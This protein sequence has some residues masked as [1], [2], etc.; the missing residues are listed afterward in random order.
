MQSQNQT[1]MTRIE[2]L[3]EELVAHYGDG[4]AKELRVAAKMLMVSLDQFRRHGGYQWPGLVREYL[5]IAVDDADR[6]D[7][8]LNANRSGKSD[9]Q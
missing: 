6:F 1:P 4:D 3:F 7:L 8:M 2:N 5:S 9:L